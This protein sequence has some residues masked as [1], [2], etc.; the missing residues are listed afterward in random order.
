VSLLRD[1]MGED[2]WRS[3][4]E[5]ARFMKMYAKSQDM[6]GV[7]LC[8]LS[9]DEKIRYSRTIKEHADNVWSW[10]YN[11]DIAQETGHIIT[12]DQQKARN[13]QIFSF[14][15]AEKFCHMSLTDCED[16]SGN[17]NDPLIDGMKEEECV[18]L[19]KKKKDVFDVSDN[20]EEF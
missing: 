6:V 9:E 13:Q 16:S 17:I 5:I 14:K 11:K 2:S 15:V 4:G 10:V 8:Q 19:S 1:S 3:L 18:N 12:I 20:L 7:L